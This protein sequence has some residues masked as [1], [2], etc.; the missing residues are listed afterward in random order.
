MGFFFFFFG[1]LGVC[2]TTGRDKIAELLNTTNLFLWES[3]L[4]SADDEH[5][6]WKETKTKKARRRWIENWGEGRGWLE[7]KS[8]DIH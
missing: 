7:E 1:D 6:T 8:K 4:E 5:A 2:V 3:N